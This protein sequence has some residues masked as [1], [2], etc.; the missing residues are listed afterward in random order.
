MECSEVKKDLPKRGELIIPYDKLL[1]TQLSTRYYKITNKNIH[2]LLSKLEQ[3]AKGY[4]SPDRADA[5]N[6][7]FWNYKS[8]RPDSKND[9]EPYKTDEDE[10]QKN[11]K[12]EGDFDLN[13]W[14]NSHRQAYQP[15]HIELDNLSDLQEELTAYNKQRKQL[16]GRN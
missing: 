7:C 13:S 10:E 1:I 9:E 15:E 4:P 14:A 16:I 2:Q 11:L 3:K 12:I 6:L 8:T 5:L